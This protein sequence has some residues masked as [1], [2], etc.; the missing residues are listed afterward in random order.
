MVGWGL[1]L[2]LLHPSSHQICTKCHWILNSVRWGAQQDLIMDHVAFRHTGN[3]ELWASGA[4]G[5]VATLTPLWEDRCCFQFSREGVLTT[6]R[7]QR[8]PCCH[9][10]MDDPSTPDFKNLWNWG[11]N[12]VKQQGLQEETAVPWP[13]QPFPKSHFLKATFFTYFQPFLIFL[14]LHTL[15]PLFF[16]TIYLHI[17]K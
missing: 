3:P 7:D 13:T 14:H 17:L 9:A 2:T 12:E 15:I 6:R 16:Y 8:L 5:E 4:N 11:E 10:S 1:Q